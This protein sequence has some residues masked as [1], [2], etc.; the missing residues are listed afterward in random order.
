MFLRNWADIDNLF[1]R[2]WGDFHRFTELVDDTLGAV[3]QTAWEDPAPPVNVWSN[4]EALVLTALAPGLDPSTLDISV[5]GSTLRLKGERKPLAL[6][7]QDT[8]HRRERAYGT[9]VRELELPCVV[10]TDKVQASYQRGILAIH[11]PRS[12]SDRPHKIQVTA[13]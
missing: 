11:L 12:E 3:A 5:H 9:F 2:P 10:D 1:W 8:Y 13:G 6:G 4:D 7:E